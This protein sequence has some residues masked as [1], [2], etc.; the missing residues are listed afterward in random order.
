MPAAHHAD[1]LR[2]PMPA[3]AQL[4]FP[5]NQDTLACDSPCKIKEVLHFNRRQHILR[6]VRRAAYV[7]RADQPIDRLCNDCRQ[8]PQNQFALGQS[9]HDA[10]PSI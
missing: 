5:G 6:A 8:D 9:Q 1:N 10:N 3:T 4:L 7:F 2:L